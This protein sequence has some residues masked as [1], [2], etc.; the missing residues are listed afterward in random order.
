MQPL[1]W[2]SSKF[3]D[4]SPCRLGDMSKNT[5]RSTV[6][7]FSTK[8]NEMR[9]IHCNQK[10]VY[11]PSINMHWPR[12]SNQKRAM[13]AECSNESSNE[14]FDRKKQNTSISND[15]RCT[16]PKKELTSDFICVQLPYLSDH[17][18]SMQRTRYVA[19]TW[20][21]PLVSV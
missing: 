2:C 10:S 15:R 4:S 6:L 14:G 12:P 1:N 17:N 7:R 18:R 16:E 3:E 19:V 20:V 21:N 8:R 13:A 11:S 5:R 9:Y